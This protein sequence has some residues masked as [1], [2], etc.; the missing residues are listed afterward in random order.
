VST[1]KPWRAR[2]LEKYKDELDRWWAEMA[3]V[4]DEALA[5]WETDGGAD[6]R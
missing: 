4:D 5:Q 1:E 2:M 3:E 6:E